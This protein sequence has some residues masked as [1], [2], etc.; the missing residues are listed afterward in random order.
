MFPFAV[1]NFY[2][3]FDGRAKRKAIV[4]KNNKLTQ[5]ALRRRG[6]G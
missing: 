2:R 5:R 1:P 3:R 6:A 4:K